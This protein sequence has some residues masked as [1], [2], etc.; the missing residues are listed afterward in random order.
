[1]ITR[2][3]MLQGVH[4]HREYYAQFVTDYHRY[5]VADLDIDAPLQVWDRLP[6]IETQ[7]SLESVGDIKSLAGKICIYK[8]ACRQVKEKK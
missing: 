3:Q 1:M 7:I 4:S 8:E 2:K 6:Q 5:L